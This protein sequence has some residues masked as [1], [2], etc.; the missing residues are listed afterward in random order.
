[1][2]LG[3]D[4]INR[5]YQQAFGGD[6]HQNEIKEIQG[7]A[8]FYGTSFD[9]V[10]GKL[11]E[12]NRY[13]QLTPEQRRMNEFNQS[14][15]GQAY[16]NLVT[17][18]EDN[19]KRA[20]QELAPGYD[21]AM[22]T[23]QSE[24]PLTKKRYEEALKRLVNQ[25]ENINAQLSAS[26][27]RFATRNQ[28]LDLFSERTGA[29]Y[30]DARTQADQ[31]RQGQERDILKRMQASGNL[32]DGKMNEATVDLSVN[33]S[34][35]LGRLTRDESLDQ[36][37]IQL[38]KNNALN[39]QTEAEL[40]IQNL[41][42]EIEFKYADTAIAKDQALLSI[43]NKVAELQVQKTQAIN[44]YYNSLND[45]SNASRLDRAKTL[46]EIAR[47]ESALQREAERAKVEAERWEKDYGLKLESMDL[48]KQQFER[49]K[50]ESDRAHG[51]QA[52]NAAESRRQFN[53]AQANAGKVEPGKLASHMT[54]MM[55]QGNFGTVATDAPSK[56]YFGPREMARNY[57][58]QQG[59]N[60]A[61][62]TKLVYD[63]LFKNDQGVP[64]AETG[65]GGN[66]LIEG[67]QQ[68]AAAM[69]AQGINP[70]TGKPY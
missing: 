41:A 6:A 7:K 70:A 17:S 27:E 30:D 31:Q 61:E 45:K 36:R 38:D 50:F 56:G 64:R 48:N 5:A 11:K 18:K 68:Q 51:L 67:L 22:K 52:S 37:Q 66:E 16:K 58:M 65:G 9:S 10:L 20:Q 28:E 21:R 69:R 3:A 62:A 2:A 54:Q 1:M 25:K 60:E 15:M 44:Q 39:S 19:K 57:A 35:I 29:K 24:A 12:S 23:I 46:E 49:S 53:V 32:R 59:L 13:T 8:E 42:N 63:T 34:D 47:Y 26:Q 14:E 40:Q 33:Y 4:T 43:K 55:R